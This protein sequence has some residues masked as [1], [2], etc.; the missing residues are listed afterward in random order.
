VVI[1]VFVNGT[2][3]SLDFPVRR[4]MIGDFAGPERL[5]VG[6]SLD[7]ATNNATRMLGPFAGG[8]VYGLVGLKGAFILGTCVN[9]ACVGIALSIAFE[10]TRGRA[11]AEPFF[12]Q[13]RQGLGIVRRS[14]ELIGIYLVTIILNV[15]GFPYASMV[16]VLGRARYQV[17]PALI[18]VLSASEGMG[19][20]LGALVIAFAARPAWFKRLYLYG[21][22]VFVTGVFCLSLAPYY[23]MGVTIMLIAGLG[24]A[25]FGAMQSTL[26]LLLAPPEAR[27]RLMGLLSVC[28][29]CAP[30]GLLNLGLLADALGAPT[31]LTIV[32]STGLVL[33]AATVLW[34][35]E[36]RR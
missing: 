9:L 32:S 35:P 28:I 17:E 10:D 23:G 24:M 31:A 22:V 19:A 29:G 15:F 5:G 4:T 1:G 33:L 14:R 21:A 27:S 6:V 26:I 20:F 2:C 30:I 36:V 7:S 18:G 25:G 8:V 11:V 16:P 13:L 12:A 34:I 3:W